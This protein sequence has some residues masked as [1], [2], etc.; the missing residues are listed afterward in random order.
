MKWFLDERVMEFES[1][2]FSLARRRSTAELH[3]RKYRLISLS[4][5]GGL[6]KGELLCFVEK[7]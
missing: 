7:G 3:P 2:T 4:R 6:C 1:M 5:I